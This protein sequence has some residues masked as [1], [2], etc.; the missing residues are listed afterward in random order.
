MRV[1]LVNKNKVDVERYKA[2]DYKDEPWLEFLSV[3]NDEEF[4]IELSEDGSDFD[5][6]W[7]QC[8]ETYERITGK[9]MP[10][11]WEEFVE[12]VFN[13]EIALALKP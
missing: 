13:Y 9:E 7:K 2:S 4:P 3:V 6:I 10:A 11:D 12:M 5:D 8:V 1:L